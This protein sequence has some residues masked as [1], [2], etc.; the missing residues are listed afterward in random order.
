M[1]TDST[2]TGFDGGNTSYDVYVSS[3]TS[4]IKLSASTVNGGSKISGD[5]SGTGSASGNININEGDN[6]ITVKVTAGN[7]SVKTYILNV[8]RA[9]AEPKSSTDNN[10]TDSNTDLSGVVTK[11]GYR[12][13]NNYLKGINPGSK[14]TDVIN[15][16]KKN[17]ANAN[18]V[19]KNS[20]GKVIESDFVGSG[21]TIEIS[22]GS[23]KLNVT[24]AIYGDASGDGKINALDLLKIQ[25]H[26]LGVNKLS[27]AALTGAD[28]SKD[29]KVNALDLLKVQKHILGVNNINQ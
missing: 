1:I 20:S 17:D 28:P 27:G 12:I 18:V 2:V 22:D 7:G 23:Y 26:I 13:S 4:S 8:N 24:V 21:S 16:I 6:K 3:S 14:A 29:G 5:I 15:S 9:K 10:A 19:I 11:S 25:K